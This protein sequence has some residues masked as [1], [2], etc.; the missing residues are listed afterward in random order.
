M[1]SINDF[2]VGDI[3]RST[4]EI[5]ESDLVEFARLSGDSNPIHLDDVYAAKTVFKRRIAHGLFLG[6][7][8]SALIASEMPGE[9]AIYLKQ[10]LSFKSP[11]FLNDVIVTEIEILELNEEKNSL[12]L[13]TTCKTNE[14]RVVIV[15]EALVKL[16]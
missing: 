12:L 2:K 1:K 14:D 16:Q 11:A 13:K 8:I 10:S 15:G 3:A 9:G 6:S 7:F 5:I 4:R